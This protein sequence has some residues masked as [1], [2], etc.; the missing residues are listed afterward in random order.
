MRNGV[1]RSRYSRRVYT[2]TRNPGP[3]RV[4]SGRECCHLIINRTLAVGR[5]LVARVVLTDGVCVRHDRFPLSPCLGRR[6]GL[7]DD[8]VE[9]FLGARAAENWR[10][11]AANL[12]ALGR[13]TDTFRG[14]EPLSHAFAAGVN[15]AVTTIATAR[16]PFRR[17]GQERGE[18][19]ASPPRR[20]FNFPTASGSIVE[21]VPRAPFD[22]SDSKRAPLAPQ[23][24]T[25][26]ERRRK[27]E[28]SE[29]PLFTRGR[30]LI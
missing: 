13:A 3:E 9:V 15:G 30:L 6:L 25:E 2:N 21:R 22:R 28:N 29:S 10:W 11:T 26:L 4:F 14:I 12:S 8:L 5:P 20:S 23:S 27:C 1:A 17:P 24:P 7:V 19:R 16:E 18:A